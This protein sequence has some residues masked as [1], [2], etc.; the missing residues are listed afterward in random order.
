MSQWKKA[1]WNHEAY[2]HSYDVYIRIFGPIKIH[3]LLWLSIQCLQ[4]LPSCSRLHFHDNTLLLALT[5]TIAIHRQ[6]SIHVFSGHQILLGL[7]ASPEKMTI[8][9]IIFDRDLWNYRNYKQNVFGYISSWPRVP[10]FLS[11]LLLQ[12][13]AGRI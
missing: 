2:V 13:N 11:M 7:R 4:L 8:V 1:R 9:R 3:K 12:R 5:E 6:F 10:W